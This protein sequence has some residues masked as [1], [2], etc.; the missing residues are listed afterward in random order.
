MY[1][2]TK[3]AQSRLKN[4]KMIIAEFFRA[5]GGA[6]DLSALSSGMGVQVQTPYAAYI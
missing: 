6:S 2:P 1:K 4:G 3:G 5:V